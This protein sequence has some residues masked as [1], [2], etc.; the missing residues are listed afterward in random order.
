MMLHSSS[1]VTLPV[2]SFSCS[3]S[4]DPPIVRRKRRRRRRILDTFSWLV[5]HLCRYVHV[6]QRDS[7]RSC[8]WLR[9]HSG[10]NTQ[11]SI[12]SDQTFMARRLCQNSIISNTSFRGDVYKYRMPQA[13]VRISVFGLA[14][15]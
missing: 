9:Q 7:L 10:R 3:G 12:E 2:V 6:S 11:N 8:N 13:I 14:R 1:I 15:L 5:H 4:S